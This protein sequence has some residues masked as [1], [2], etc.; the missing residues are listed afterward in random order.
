MEQK[1]GT[2]SGEMNFPHLTAISFSLTFKC[3]LGWGVGGVLI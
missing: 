2:K 3:R 1:I